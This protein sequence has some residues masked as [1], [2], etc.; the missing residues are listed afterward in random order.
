[1]LKESELERVITALISQIHA[2]RDFLDGLETILEQSQNDTEEHSKIF[3]NCYQKFC[4]YEE[5]LVEQIKQLLFRQMLL[6]DPSPEE[7]GFLAEVEGMFGAIAMEDRIANK[8]REDGGKNFLE[9]PPES[10]IS[11]H[12]LALDEYKKRASTLTEIEGLV[13]KIEKGLENLFFKKTDVHLLLS[14]R[15]LPK[16]HEILQLFG[17]D[18]AESKR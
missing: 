7:A 5:G 2:L 3:K 4:A 12:S 9:M 10:Y 13:L 1:M 18:P 8:I 16:R 15:E 11:H 14:P 17:L 6:S